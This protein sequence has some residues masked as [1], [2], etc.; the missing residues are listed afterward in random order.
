[1]QKLKVP[2]DVNTELQDSPFNAWSRSVLP[3]MLHLLPGISSLLISTF[4][5]HSPAFFPNLSQVFLALA[6]AS[7]GSCVGLQ[8][9][10]GYLAGCRLPC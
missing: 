3:C 8:N 6:A 10:I 7:T 9:E 1:M 5:V 4:L 2:S